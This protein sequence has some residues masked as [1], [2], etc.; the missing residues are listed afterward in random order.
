MPTNTYVRST[1]FG[2]DLD[3]KFV[4]ESKSACLLDNSLVTDFRGNGKITL[5][6]EET[7]GLGNFSKASGYPQGAVVL[8]HTDYTLSMDRAT[9]F[10]LNDQE[11]RHTGIDNL[12]P[13]LAGR[14]IKNHVVPEVDAYTFSKAFAIANEMGHA[15][16]GA[17]LAE[18]SGNSLEITQ[19][20]INQCQD[21]VGDNEEL[22]AFMNSDFYNGLMHSKDIYRHID[23]GDF[24]KGAVNTKI[25]RLNEVPLVKVPGN[26]MKTAY[27]FRNGSGE[28]G[29]EATDNATNIGCIVLPRRGALMLIKEIEKTKYFG[30][31][32]DDNGDNHR[33]LFHMFY[34]ALAKK[35]RKGTIFCYTYGN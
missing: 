11:V 34:D 21:Q 14:F 13:G 19:T 33:I 30:P 20:L 29:F 6:D 31:E 24:Q 28:F 7:D 16:S 27:N 35:S 15:E 26:R 4:I 3:Q 22:I 9:R 32:T 10:V 18:A 8:N 2:K 23:T 25:K 12:V 17:N 1:K 5:A